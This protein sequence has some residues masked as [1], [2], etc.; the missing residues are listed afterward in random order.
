MTEGSARLLGVKASRGAAVLPQPGAGTASSAA[1]CSRSWGEPS[2]FN[3]VHYS[4][5][6]E[7]AHAGIYGFTCSSEHEKGKKKYNPNHFLLQVVP[8]S[9]V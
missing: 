8:A 2:L 6:G 3:C 9:A 5:G 1:S 7:Q 4:R